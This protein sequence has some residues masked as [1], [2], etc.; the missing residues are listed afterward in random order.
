MN[1]NEA[2][3][4]QPLGVELARLPSSQKDWEQIP[5]LLERG[6]GV[7]IINNINANANQLEDILQQ[8]AIVVGHSLLPYDR[9]PGQSPAVS[10]HLALL[11]NYKARCDNDIVAG[12]Q[13]GDAIAEYKP[14]SATELSEWHTDGSFLERPKTFI[15]LYAPQ[16]LNNALPA[17]GGETR[18]CSTHLTAQQQEKYK[19]WTSIH[20]WKTFM[21][22]LEARDPHRPK[23]TPTQCR[24][25]PDQRWPLVN[26]AKGCLYIN[27]KNT[28]AIYNAQGEKVPDDRLVY[29]LAQEMIDQNGVYF[30]QWKPGQLVVWDNHALLHAATPFDATK[31]ER[32]LYRAEFGPHHVPC[33][34]STVK[35]GYLEP[36][37]QPVA[38]VPSG[39]VVVVDTVS[40]SR[41]PP[42][43]QFVFIPPALFDIQ[44][45]V[46]DR[47]GPHILTGPI[48]V[49]SAEPG[50]VLQIDIL[51][52]R[53]TSDWAWTIHK[54]S[55]EIRHTKLDRANRQA[56]TSW[57]SHLD[58]HPFFGVLGVATDQRVSSVPPNMRYGGNLDL[59]LL[60]AGSTLYLPVHQNGGQL[61]VGDGHA[62]QGD[63]ECCGTAL[64]TCLTGT[65]RLTVRKDLPHLQTTRAET[66]QELIAIGIADTVD[67]AVAIALKHM[68]EW[69]LELR[70]NN[71]MTIVDS[72]CLLSVA[73]DIRVTQIVN[74]TTRGAHV[75][76]EKKH[77]PPLSSLNES[78]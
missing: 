42:P 15:A 67:E 36:S 28:A 5:D 57:G 74:G 44:T 9:W 52:V 30:H 22:F 20:S 76:L 10:K 43:E 33:K 23:V 11:G 19:N 12:A 66:S 77:L 46:K 27:P 41:I 8:F 25:K 50:D 3:F 13:L 56:E 53:L 59:K 29:K 48:A 72:E 45:S 60:T 51:N 2:K 21:R 78:S 6:K 18:F 65:F 26:S 31:Y 64:E 35:W 55:Q 17:E 61:F 37:P 38:T 69:I 75:V 54:K 63:G 70:P 40:G 39:A 32:L 58:C 14:A 47:V 71:Q 73:G 68:V 1:N 62:R 34:P 24:A 16:E 49:Q 4:L 7:L